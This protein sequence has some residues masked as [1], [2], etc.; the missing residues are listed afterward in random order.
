[1]FQ[2]LAVELVVIHKRVVTVVAPVVVLLLLK[3]LAELAE[4]VG[5][6]VVGQEVV[7]AQQGRH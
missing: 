3:G 5:V 4:T 7:V 2:R 6:M 1:V